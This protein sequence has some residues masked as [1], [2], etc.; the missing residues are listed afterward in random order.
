MKNILVTGSDG[1]I[2]SH[3]TENLVKEGYKVKAFTYYNSFGRLGW[4]DSISSDI[5]NDIEIFSGDIRDPNG[6][7]EA[8]EKY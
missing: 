5:K 3:L 8:I 1:F 7:R 6:V 4:L 2:G